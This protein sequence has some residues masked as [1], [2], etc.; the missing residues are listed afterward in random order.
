MC[1]FSSKPNAATGF[2]SPH[3]TGSAESA[4]GHRPLWFFFPPSNQYRFIFTAID[5]YTRFV[6]AV[7]IRNKK[8]LTIAKVLVK[9]VF[10][11]WGGYFEIL[12]DLGTEFENEIVREVCNL[13]A[14][15]KIRS[16]GYRPQTSGVIEVW[17]R[18][19]HSMMAKVISTNQRDWSEYLD[20]VTFCYNATV[21]SATG[22]SPFFLMTV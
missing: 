13:L 1:G 19:L 6:T 17:H 21:H 15:H 9:H 14:I 3:E 10:L 20:Y 4:A 11:I 7:G 5:P 16:S 8:A 12:S 2:F 22:F 18:V